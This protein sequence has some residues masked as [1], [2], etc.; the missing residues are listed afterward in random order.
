LNAQANFFSQ[1]LR[2]HGEIRA[3][4]HLNG[5][6]FVDYTDMAF[7]APVSFLFWVLGRMDDLNRITSCMNEQDENTYFGETIA[8]LCLLQSAVQF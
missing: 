4:Y 3:G 1:E 5:K 8:M 6:S 2:R 7:L